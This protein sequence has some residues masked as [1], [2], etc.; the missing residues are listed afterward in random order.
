[1]A[2]AGSKLVVKTIDG[3]VNDTIKPIK[4]DES[5]ATHFPMLK[6]TDGAIDWSCPSITIHNL[7]RGVNPW[8]GAY[9]KIGE[10]VLK[11]WSGTV[12]NLSSNAIAGTVVS[13]KDGLHIATGEGVY[14]V[15]TL[16]LPGKKKTESKS[17]IN[18]SR[19]KV[20]DILING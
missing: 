17:W 13:I 15:S 1:M 5:L 6:K 2:I 4:Q 11:I 9:C 20:G 7:V 3:L 12:S 16:Q 8:P 14:K 10:D 19:I 18:G